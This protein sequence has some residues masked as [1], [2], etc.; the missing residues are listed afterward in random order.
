M[1]FRPSSIVAIIATA[2]TLSASHA[3]AVIVAQWTYQ[4][5]TPT[6]AGPHAAEAGIFA[7]TSFASTNSGGTI[8]SPAGN[9]TSNAFSS[10]GWAAGEYY[11][12]L[13]STVGYDTITLSFAQAASGTGPRDFQFQYSTDGVSY[14][15][16]GSAYIG[17]TTDFNGGAFNGANVLSLD[18]SSV[19]ALNNN[20]TVGFRIAVVG[21][22][23]ENGGTIAATGTFRNDDF[24]VNGLA[25]AVPEASSF[26][27]AGLVACAAG[28]KCFGRRKSA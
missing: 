26:L 25:V 22:A 16:F 21:T 3:H 19:T 27:F 15:N 28:L 10:N 11:Q 1:R 7:G 2:V 24:T 8:S 23:S 20:P 12:F 9:G 14:V 4:T 13:T 18:L 5:T 17:P 6:T